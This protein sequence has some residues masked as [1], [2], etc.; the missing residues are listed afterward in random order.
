MEVKGE[1]MSVLVDEIQ[2]VKP[3][4]YDNDGPELTHTRWGYMITSQEAAGVVRRIGFGLVR[5]VG[6]VLLLVAAGMW[7]LPGTSVH[8]DVLSFKIA[9]TVLFGLLGIGA[10]WGSADVCRDE[11]QVDL[12]RQELRRGIRHTNGRFIS[13]VVLP[14][15]DAGELFLSKPKQAGE[16]AV[17]Y[18][19]RI[20]APQALEIAAGAEDLLFP[21]LQRITSDL[22]RERNR[23]AV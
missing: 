9:L 11:M 17:L 10:L 6:A 2:I 16:E 19:R 15:K 4:R 22:M 14:L 5:Y 7:V 18:I 1:K 3:S 12:E 20:S 8:P 13:T 23:V 21:I